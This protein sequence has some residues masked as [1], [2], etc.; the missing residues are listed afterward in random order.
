MHFVQV[1]FHNNNNNN[2]VKYLPLNCLWIDLNQES[3]DIDFLSEIS[4]SRFQLSHL[5]LLFNDKYISSAVNQPSQ[6]TLKITPTV[7]LPAY[8]M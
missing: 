1:F 2:T 5:W 8:R 4:F 6:M 7:W 3:G